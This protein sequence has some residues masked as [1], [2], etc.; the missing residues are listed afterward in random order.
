MMLTD[1]IIRQPRFIADK[2]RISCEWIKQ[3]TE[4]KDFNY[5]CD[6]ENSVSLWL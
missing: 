3:N 4:L 6:A 5:A 1:I 2:E